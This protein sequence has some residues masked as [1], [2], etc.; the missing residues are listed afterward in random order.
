MR[1]YRLIPISFLSVGNHQYGIRLGLL[2]V[3]CLTCGIHAAQDRFGGVFVPSND[4]HH[5]LAGMTW[6]QLGSKMTEYGQQGQKLIDVEIIQRHAPDTGPCEPPTFAG[7]WREGS[8]GQSLIGGLAWPDF[9][10][11][12]QVQQ[13]QGMR[14][15]DLETHVE[16]G[17]RKYVGV[18]RTAP[19]T[20]YN[21]TPPRIDLEYQKVETGMRWND[22]TRKFSSYH[23]L[24][25]HLIDI[26]TYDN[27][28][29]RYWAAVWNK[30]TKDEWLNALRRDSFE[31]FQASVNGTQELVDVESWRA[32]GV[33]MVVGLFNKSS[34]KVIME[35]GEHWPKFYNLWQ[36]L[37]GDRKRLVD[38]EV[39]PD[40]TD[41]RWHNTIAQTLNGISMGWSF[42]VVESGVLAETGAEG[43][44]RSPHEWINAS[45]PMEPDSV[46]NIA[47]ITKLLTVVGILERHEQLGENFSF[48]DWPIGY[49]L[50]GTYAGIDPGVW[51]VTIRNVLSQQ[52]GMQE[53]T[54]KTT[55]TWNELGS[56]YK[57]RIG[58]WV[59]LPLVGT[60]GTGPRT[61]YNHY[62]NMLILILEA[63]TGEDYE[64]WMNEHVFE[65]IAI[66]PLVGGPNTLKTA[67][68]YYKKLPDIMPGDAFSQPGDSVFEGEGNG[69][70]WY[71]S[72]IDLAR[73]AA[74]F[75]DGTILDPN[76]VQMMEDEV[77]AWYPWPEGT[78]DYYQKNGGLCNGHTRG[79]QCD[80]MALDNEFDVCV[81]TNS[82]TSYAF[83]DANQPLI[84]LED[85]IVEAYDAPED[86]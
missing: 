8:Y 36:A 58:Q 21:P 67:P 62:F 82:W 11:Q 6:E 53:P 23:R 85:L 81:M 25:W 30:G 72:A 64:A 46:M 69:G 51:N 48:I 37:S 7:V 44:A 31:G 74:S 20:R 17:M 1:E 29:A 27:H 76:T 56:N 77:M 32:G 84:S 78:T 63:S 43:W 83:D 68:R 9:K 5:L 15:M 40:T 49:F 24:G 50:Q 52:T 22:L 66:G 14:L 61:Y 60:P 26:E 33:R 19:D 3:C 71:A 55:P 47:S 70:C 42:A 39:Y 86:W 57:E 54:H 13:G 38:L 65:P 18:F 28:G 16:C 2:A 59:T 73:L 34:D 75:R 10:A 12:V 80:V 45:Q 35:T 41:R 79:L 4:A